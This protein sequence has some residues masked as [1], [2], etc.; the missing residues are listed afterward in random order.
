MAIPRLASYE[1]PGREAVVQGAA[2]WQLDP[3]RS[4]L[5]I[6][7]MQRYFMAFYGESS[8]I[9][10]AVI[11]NVVRIAAAARAAG[12][13]VFYTA[14][15]GAQSRA[16]RALLYD[17]WGPGI[18]AEAEHTS[19]VPELEPQPGDTR[20]QKH[21]YSAFYGTALREMLAQ[22]GR[23]HLV[24]TG[25]YAHI[26]C[27]ATAVDAFMADVQPFFVVDAVADFSR[28]E[29]LMAA[30]HV[31]KRCGAVV[32]TTAVV[33]AFAA[34]LTGRPD[35]TA[36]PES[37]FSLKA[38]LATLLDLPMTKIAQE[39]HLCDLGHYSVSVMQFAGSWREL[40]ISYVALFE[41]PSPQAWM[42][43]VQHGRGASRAAE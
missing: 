33:S 28:A 36:I 21:L 1:L 35:V 43:L 19:F 27:L 22:G 30:N 8:P 31:S 39:A 9:A 29:H 10:A 23:T 13:P 34:S 32:D 37:L 3:A 42:D 38:S 14:Q 18:G 6:H 16:Q 7:D 20:I 17:F 15:P 2:S 24:I 4:A 26:G 12:V 41:N 11:S 5:L 40:Q 25:V